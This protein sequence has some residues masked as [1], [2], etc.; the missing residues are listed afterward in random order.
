MERGV[1]STRSGITVE[2]DRNLLRV[3]VICSKQDRDKI[4][5]ILKNFPYEIRETDSGPQILIRTEGPKTSAQKL[6]SQVAE[7]VRS[8][9]RNASFVVNR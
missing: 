7:S 6:T 5:S 4:T 8:A 9:L 3:S 2:A 1:R